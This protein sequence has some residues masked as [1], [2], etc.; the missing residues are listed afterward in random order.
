MITHS[1]DLSPQEKLGN[2]ARIWF[3][4]DG[5]ADIAQ[6]ICTGAVLTEPQ[7]DRLQETYNTPE[8]VVRRACFFAIYAPP[9][10]VFE[11]MGLHILDK[12][13]EE[14]TLTSVCNP[15]LDRQIVANIMNCLY[16]SLTARGDK[17]G[18]LSHVHKHVKAIERL[19]ADMSAVMRCLSPAGP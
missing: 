10:S 17:E 12:A 9:G 3:E 16:R 5:Y 7:W 4:R 14:Y 19:E 15:S 11:E 2:F 1:H 8:G 6:A 13:V 18:A